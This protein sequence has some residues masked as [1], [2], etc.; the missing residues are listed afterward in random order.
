MTLAT[1]ITTLHYYYYYY[2]YIHL[3][4]WSIFCLFS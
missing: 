4:L 2:L 1:S 3:Y